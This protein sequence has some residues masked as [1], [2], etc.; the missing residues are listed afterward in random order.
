MNK[1]S[2]ILLDR[3]KDYEKSPKALELFLKNKG[4]EYNKDWAFAVQCFQKK[5]NQDRNKDGLPPLPFMAIRQKLLALA[6]IDDARWFFRECQKYATTKDNQGN[7]NTFS[8]CFFGSL[9]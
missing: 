7:K 3:I 6:E 1:L 8:K 9:K 4:K 2:D 5:I